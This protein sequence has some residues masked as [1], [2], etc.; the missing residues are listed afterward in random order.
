MRGEAIL[1]VALLG[2]STTAHAVTVLQQTAPSPTT[3]TYGTQ[4]EALTY[5]PAGDVTARVTAV[6]LQLGPGNNATSGCE[7]ADFAGFAAGNIALI[8][9]GFCTFEQKAENAAAAGAVGVLIFNQGNTVDRMDVFSGTLTAA[10]TASLMVFSLSYNLGAELASTAGLTMRMYN[11]FPIVPTPEPGTLA[12][13]GLGL[14]GL[15]LSRRRQ[16]D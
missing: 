10:Y 16:A 3:Y 4:F 9:R 2:A 5:S 11:E 1:A 12:L 6:D 14:A 15:G 13:L 7:A 8:Q